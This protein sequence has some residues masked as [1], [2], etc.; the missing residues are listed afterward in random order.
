MACKC[1]GYYYTLNA[2]ASFDR[3]LT[4]TRKFLLRNVSAIRMF[5]NGFF[6]CK[7]RSVAGN[8]RIL[9]S[10]PEILMLSL[11]FLFGYL[12]SDATEIFYI[13]A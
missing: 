1:G 6:R 2:K 3:D 11:F 8:R 13:R 10:L 12:E 5:T 9:R 7:W 4:K